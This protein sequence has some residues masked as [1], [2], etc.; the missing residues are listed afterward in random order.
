MIVVNYGSSA[1]LAR[2]LGPLSEAE[3]SLTVVVVD[4][5]TDQVERERVAELAA[6]R[7]WSL[8]T[9]AAN[10]G[11]GGGM[12]LG[13]AAAH[14]RGAEVTVL[15]NPDAVLAPAALRSLVAAVRSAPLTM[16]A[17]RIE[18]SDG[19]HWFAGADLYLDDGRVR[20]ARRRIPGARTEPWLTGACLA[21]TRELW[22]R[23][24]GFDERYFLYWEDIDLSWRV[25]CVGGDLLVRQDIVAVH[26]QGGTQQAEAG[27]YA[28]SRLYYYYNVRNRLLFAA[29]HLS[30]RDARRWRRTALTVGV[31]VLRQGG[32]RQL[33]RPRGPV[34]ALARGLR[35]GFRLTRRYGRS[36]ENPARP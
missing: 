26:D 2:N 32:R 18:R 1:L 3:P 4:N 31:E 30:P 34:A 11:F 19:T 28:K 8:V 5:P 14:D 23:V 27:T 16:V 36:A 33:L 17:P 24:G 21:L 20:S 12:N 7:G 15:L 13:V 22:E 35:D 6:E 10:L 25:R 9:P 29:L